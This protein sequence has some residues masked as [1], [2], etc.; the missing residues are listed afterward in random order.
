TRHTRFPYTTLF[1][2]EQA[3]ASYCGVRN[4]IGVSNGLDALRLVL[5]AW[6]IGPQDEVIVPAHTFIATWLAVSQTGALPVPVDIDPH[7][8]RSEEHTS[9]LQSREN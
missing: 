7:T 3:F 8:F 2:S 9:E 5:H 6:G 1:R 4:C